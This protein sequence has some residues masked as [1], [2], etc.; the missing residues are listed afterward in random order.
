M[1]RAIWNGSISFGLVTIP[2]KLYSAVS[3]KAIR[4]NQLDSRSGSRI[5]M[6]RVSAADGADVESDDIVRGYEYMKGQYVIID[7]EELQS[8]M[9]K[10]SRTVDIEAFVDL[11][12][13]DPVFCDSAYHVAPAAGFEKPYK[14]LTEAMDDQNKVAIA[15]FVRQNKQYLAA[16]RPK[17]GL[18]HLSTMVYSDEIS[19]AS[20]IDEF[21]TLDDIEISEPEREMARQLIS[22]LEADF[23]A[24]S[25]HDTHREQLM[26]LLNKK[27]AGEEIVTEVIAAEDDKVIDLLAALEASVAAAKAARA[28]G[29]D[30]PAKPKKKRA[31]KKR[32]PTKRAATVKTEE[33]NPD[34]TDEVAAKRKRKSA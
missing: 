14:L 23:D 22:S 28:S 31:A 2:V 8:V 1:P 15:R 5:K 17:G 33:V 27:A 18:L 30:A 29:D 25:F 32:A 6:K 10:A 9:P 34:P 24:D 12:D 3:K 19:A 21:E 26:D 7:D 16:I 13:I 11:A 20:D 4:F